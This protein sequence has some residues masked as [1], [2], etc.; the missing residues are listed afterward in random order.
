MA[1][2]PAGRFLVALLS[3][4]DLAVYKLDAAG[5]QQAAKTYLDTTNYVEVT[6]LPEKK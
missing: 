6:L 3:N 4:G 5:I 2:D 1:L